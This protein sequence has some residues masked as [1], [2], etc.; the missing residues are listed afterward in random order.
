MEVYTKSIQDIVDFNIVSH[1]M[2]AFF[3]TPDGW[4]RFQEVAPLCIETVFC[5]IVS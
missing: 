4:L 1:N 5:E 2:C 3:L